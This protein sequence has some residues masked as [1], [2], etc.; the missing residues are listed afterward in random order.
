VA[1][2]QAA[3]APA[4]MA[5]AID[6][7]FD[8]S[9]GPSKPGYTRVAPAA[10][11]ADDPGYGYEP[12]AQVASGDNGN[13]TTSDKPFIFSAKVPEG[14]F[15]VTVTFG[16]S[17]TATTTTFKAESGRLMLERVEVPAGQVAERTFTT[18]VRTPQAAQAAHQRHRPRRG[19]PRPVRRRQLA[20]LG[21]Q[22]EH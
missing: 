14:N 21:Q 6:L 22:A 15:N 3:P 13:T 11:Y 16:D 9:A 12:G 2:A 18:N 8:F 4:P 5:A 1:A 17:T 10:I 20:R 19:E 7:K